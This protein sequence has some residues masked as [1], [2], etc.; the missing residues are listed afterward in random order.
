MG[1]RPDDFQVQYSWTAASVPPPYHYEYDVTIGPGLAGSI[2]YLPDYPGAGTPT[3][4]AEFTVTETDLDALYQLVVRQGVLSRRW[5]ELRNPP[6]GGD[7]S[8]IQVQA[9]GK[10]VRVHSLMVNAERLD[11][12]NK[13]VTKLVPQ[14]IWDT[15]ASQREKYEQEHSNE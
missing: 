3:W 1:S 14:E 8:G 12:I 15:L 10:T 13:A 9:N 11:P 4:T 5:R 6:V 2:V 7:T